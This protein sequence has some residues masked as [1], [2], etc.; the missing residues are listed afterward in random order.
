[1]HCFVSHLHEFRESHGDFNIYNQQGMEKLNDIITV[2][3]FRKSS[4]NWLKKIL[5][6]NNEQVQQD[7]KITTNCK[8][9]SQKNSIY[10]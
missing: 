1:M 4:K 6:T 3:Y 5:G 2:D 8:M 10:S 7:R 9:K